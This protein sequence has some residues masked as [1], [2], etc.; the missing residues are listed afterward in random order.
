MPQ[1][2]S[3]IGDSC[4]ACGA[5]I[6]SD[7]NYCHNCGIPVSSETVPFDLTERVTTFY[8]TYMVTL[9]SIIQAAALGYLLLAVLD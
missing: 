4:K 9:I 8:P 1:Q 7:A 3:V 2:P 6:V 5:S